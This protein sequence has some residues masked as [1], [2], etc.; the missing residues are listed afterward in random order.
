MV[1]NSEVEFFNS[2]VLLIDIGGTNI[3]TAVDKI[4]GY[5]TG[6][7]SSSIRQT[8]FNSPTLGL[9]D[10]NARCVNVS[11]TENMSVNGVDCLGASMQVQVYTKGSA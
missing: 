9:S 2:R 5:I 1:I 10:T 8:I 4:E 3:R 7:G 6:S 11:S